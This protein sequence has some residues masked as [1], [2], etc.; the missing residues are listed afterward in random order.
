MPH[1]GYKKCVLDAFF[2]LQYAVIVVFFALI[3]NIHIK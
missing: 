2:Y 1:Y 3:P